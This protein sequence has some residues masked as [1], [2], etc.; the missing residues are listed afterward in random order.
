MAHFAEINEEGIVVRVIVADQDFIDSGAVG[1]PMYWIKTSYNTKGGVHYN[2]E[3]QPDGLPA[4]RKNFASI[5]FK[6]DAALDAFIPPQPYLSWLLDEE[7]CLWQAPTPKPD[8][9]ERYI[10]DEPTLSWVRMNS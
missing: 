2:Q 9:G 6:Y 7:S 10:W 1:D 3:G 8:D 4:I 5:G